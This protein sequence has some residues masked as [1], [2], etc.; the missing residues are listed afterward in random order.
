MNVNVVANDVDPDGTIDPASVV[1]TT[2]AV[3]QRGG[4][5]VS[6]SVTAP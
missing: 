5:V 3:S 1:I 4:T 6:Q 2:G